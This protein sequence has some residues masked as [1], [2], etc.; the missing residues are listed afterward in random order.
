MRERCVIALGI[1]EGLDGRHLHMVVGCGFWAEAGGARGADTLSEQ[2][3][4]DREVPMKIYAADWKRDG[5]AAGTS[6][7]I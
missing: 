6:V 3:A 7:L 5:R 2:W 4:Q 1:S